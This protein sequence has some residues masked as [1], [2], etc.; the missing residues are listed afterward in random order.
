MRIVDHR[1]VV[2]RRDQRGDRTLWRSLDV[3]HPEM[4]EICEAAKVH[5]EDQNKNAWKNEQ[6]SGENSADWIRS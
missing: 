5:D 1:P 3:L 2:V 4:S 6:S